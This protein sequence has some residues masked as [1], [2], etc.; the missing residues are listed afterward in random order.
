MIKHKKIP[1]S[2]KILKEFRK[3]YYIHDK[4]ECWNWKKLYRKR[5][6]GVFRY[7]NEA[8]AAHRVSY[9]IFKGEIP[10]GMLV[11]HTC[12]NRRCVNPDHLWLGTHMD[13]S[14]DMRAKGRDDYSRY[15]SENSN[16]KLSII[17]VLKIH[18]YHKHRG[19]GSKRLSKIFNTPSSNVQR[20]L[21]Y[22]IWKIVKKFQ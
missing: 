4:T 19:F 16:A 14:M 12:D 5:G 20:I 7:D 15:G 3:H 11:C 8:Y 21:K 13:N 17:K 10:D 18:S 1:F 9:R 2:L 6:Y 22:K